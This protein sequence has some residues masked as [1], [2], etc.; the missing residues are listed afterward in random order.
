MK[1]SPVLRVLSTL[2]AIIMVV[3][4]LPVGTFTVSAEATPTYEITTV[5]K[6]TAV[7]SILNDELEQASDISFLGNSE[8]MGYFHVSEGSLPFHEGIVLSTGRVTS[9]FSSNEADTFNASGFDKLTEIY[10]AS[11]FAGGSTYDAAVLSFSVVPSSPWLSFKYFFA[12]TEYDQDQRYND[13]FALFVVDDMGTADTADDEWFNIAFLPDGEIVSVNAT[14]Q[15][16]IS[17]SGHTVNGVPFGFDGYTNVFTADATS[18]YNSKGEKVIQADKRIQ[19]CFAIADAGDSTKNSAIFLQS[20]SFKFISEAQNITFQSSTFTMYEG[21]I[22]ETVYV[23]PELLVN[24]TSGYTCQWYGSTDGATWSAISGQTKHTF[25]IPTTLTAGEYYYKCIVKK[26][27]YSV[28]SKLAHVII[29]KKQPQIIIVNVSFDPCWDMKDIVSFPNVITVEKDTYLKSLPT[30]EHKT[31]LFDGWYL[32]PGYQQEM[33]LDF[34]IS[35]NLILYAKW[36]EPVHTPSDWILDYPATCTENGLQYKICLDCGK[37][38]QSEYIPAL[39]H[40]FVISETVAASC[41][42]DGYMIL[43]C[44]RCGATKTQVIPAAGHQFDSKNV[45]MVCGYVRPDHP[46]DFSVTVV[47]PTCTTM[48]YTV[49]TCTLCGYFYHADFIEPTGHHWDNGVVTVEKTCTTDGIKLYTC[50]ACGATMEEILPAGHFWSEETTVPASCYEDGYKTKTCTVCGAIEVEVIPAGHTWGPETV[51]SDPDCVTPGISRHTCLVC[52]LTEDFEVPALGHHF[53]NG[54]CTRCGAYYMDVVKPSPEQAQYGVYFNIDDVVSNYGP[55]VINQYG[56]MLDYNKGAKFEKV[57]VYLTQ[58][59]TMWRRCIAFVGEDVTYATFVPYLSYGEE[60]RYSGLTSPWINL[61]PLSEGADGIWRYCEY[62]T[63]GANLEDYKGDLLL[64]LYDIAQAGEK[65]KIFDNLDEMIAWLKGEEECEHQ[66]GPWIV[67]V[68]PTADTEGSKHRVCQLCGEVEYAVIPALGDADVWDGS[69]ADGFGGGTGTENDPYLIYTAAQ[70]AYLAKTTNEGNTYSG[71]YFKLMRDLDLNNLE[72]TP[73][74][75]GVLCNNAWN[76]IQSSTFN[77]NFDGNWHTIYNLKISSNNTTF[78]GLFGYTEGSEIKDLGLDTVEITATNANDDRTKSGGLVG[79][80]YGGTISR[81]FVINAYIQ[82]YGDGVTATGLLVGLVAYE[83]GSNAYLTDCYVNGSVFGSGQVAGV[84]GATYDGGGATISRCYAVASVHGES[85]ICSHSSKKMGG[86]ISA[87]GTASITSSFFVGYLTTNGGYSSNPIGSGTKTNCHYVLLD[88]NSQTTA[89]SN[90]QSQ[91]WIESNLGWDFDTV[92]TFESGY[93]YPVLQGFSGGGTFTPHTHNYVLTDEQAPTC[94]GFGH[95]VYTCSE[96]GHSYFVEIGPLGHLPGEWIIDTEPG[97]VTPGLKHTVCLRCGQSLESIHIPALGHN[98]VSTMI[99]EPTCEEPG[100]IEHRCTRCDDYYWTYVYGEH[101]FE[102]TEYVEPTCYEDGHYTY[103]CL[104]CGDSYDEIIPGGHDYVAHIIEMPTPQEDGL[105]RYI[106][107]RCGDSYDIVIP[108]RPNAT[109]LLVQDRFPWTTNANAD[110]LNRLK[111][112]GYI[113]DWDVTT[114]A[115]F[116]SVNLSDYNVIYIANDQTTAT[117]DQLANFDASITEFVEAGGV[118]VYGACDHGWAAGNIS[119]ALPG[120]VT[121][122]NYY[123]WHNYIANPTHPIVTGELTDGQAL[124]D[125]LLYSTYSSH[126]YFNNLP[127]DAGVILVDANACP[128]LVE[129]SLGNGKVIVSG[130]TWEYTYVR[131]MVNGT[132]FAKSVYDDLL[133]YAVLNSNPCDHIW[134]AGEVVEPGCVTWGYTIHTCLQCGAT[135]RDQYTDPI[136][137]H[138]W[139]EWIIDFPATQEEEGLKHRVCQRCGL[140]DYRTI[141]VDSA[142]AIILSEED[143]VMIGD[144]IT[145]RVELVGCDPITA[146][147]MELLFDE[148]KFDFV[149]SRWI[150]NADM[151]DATFNK[152]TAGWWDATNVNTEVFEFTLR[153]REATPATVVSCLAKIELPGVGYKIELPTEVKEVAIVNCLHENGHYESIDGTYHVFVC[154]GCGYHSVGLHV[155]GETVEE[156]RIEATCNENGSYDL[157]VYCELCGEELERETV[158]IPQTHLDL[159]Y[160][161]R[162]PTCTEPGHNIV[163]CLSCGYW[164]ET[165]D[166][167]A[168]ALG[169]DWELVDRQDPTCLED[170]WEHYVCRRI[171]QNPDVPGFGFPDVVTYCNAELDVVIPHTGD[172][173]VPGEPVV[174]N[175]V[176]PTCTEPGY[177]DLITYCTYCGEELSRDTIEIPELGHLAGDPVIENETHPGYC[178]YAYDL[179]VYCERECCD[180]VELAREHVEVD[181]DWSEEWLCDGEMHWHICRVCDAL[182][183]LDEHHYDDEFDNICNDCDWMRYIIADYN[184]DGIVNSRDA[185]Y[186]LY[187]LYFPELY[188]ISQPMRDFNK[189]AIINSR[190]AIYLLRYLFWPDDYPLT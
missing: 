34:Q 80:M 132:S 177:Y 143:V 9:A 118:V 54:Y 144:T 147:S 157:V 83:N 95:M 86:I 115:N 29:L 184:E 66:W 79:T 178:C 117:Y 104:I 57:G 30:A 123:S 72:W 21:E 153:A 36:K 26:D 107:S 98:Y 27:Q 136:G 47:A 109:I 42:K 120:G 51:L 35:D 40:D 59:G 114:T 124:T 139:G 99:K 180:G 53:V 39:G 19:L 64:S 88:Q 134:D 133:V 187:H 182:N 32:D 138:D 89:L 71:K 186:F 173:H 106:C 7:S 58:D 126:T 17:V 18:L 44:T 185:I 175:V 140:E 85:G 168:P 181:H 151:Q 146:M 75:K 129:Y 46:H 56:A 149:E 161:Y 12:T 22:N 142:R 112:T 135:Y 92:W 63:I 141:P 116:G 148:D 50:K 37:V 176:D 188:P 68:Q 11:G 82:N 38:L 122:G 97:C 100:I 121:K 31:L 171:I 96:C 5:S 3:L 145:F 94:T 166:P 105:I 41:T 165:E 65:T 113:T 155:P 78:N 10:Q 164:N 167:S 190:D 125:E 62:A 131:N 90:L 49:Y 48:G 33:T 119:Y 169:H 4:V 111:N 70:L 52:G 160:G 172:E 61:F 108:A 150:V 158:V 45:C 77:G 93:D 110:I 24:A 76:T 25:Q 2:L 60:I 162:Y 20:N 15:S 130:L 156:N 102:I 14:R 6:E 170:G 28:E 8:Q 189:D 154:D 163:A 179:V 67:D 87:Y 84:L 127:G 159:V 43:S 101:N 55:A 81:C 174:E 74:G 137:S 103:T 16:H 1:Q 152:A 183:A 91:A 13:I 73:I 128:T 69:I 23:Q